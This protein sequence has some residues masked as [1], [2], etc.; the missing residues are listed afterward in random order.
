M[1]LVLLEPV[2]GWHQGGYQRLS[3]IAIILSIVGLLIFMAI[4]MND[5]N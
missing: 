3:P 4:P 2:R 5:D 1:E